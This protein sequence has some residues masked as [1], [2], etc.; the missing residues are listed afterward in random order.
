VD[1]PVFGEEEIAFLRECQFD[2]AASCGCELLSGAVFWSD[3][4]FMEFTGLSRHRG[5]GFAGVLF[6]YR[7]SLLV[8]SPREELRFAWDV[9]RAACPEWIGFRPERTTQ[10]PHWHSFVR[11]ELDSY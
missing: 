8:G 4:R 9:A 5:R 10:A 6:A 1:G 2:P 3:E 11:S 7:T